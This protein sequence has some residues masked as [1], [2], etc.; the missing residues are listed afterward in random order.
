MPSA[1]AGGAERVFVNLLRSLD[2]RLFEPVC[3]LVDASGPYLELLPDDVRRVAG[4]GRRL[5]GPGLP[6]SE[7]CGR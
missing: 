7:L 3:L 4:G 1:R 6:C 2:R 5:V